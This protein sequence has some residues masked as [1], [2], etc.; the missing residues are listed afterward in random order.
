MSGAVN[1]KAELGT[2]LELE[3]GRGEGLIARPLHPLPP[4]YLCLSLSRSLSRTW[5]L[6][7]VGE[8]VAVSPTRRASSPRSAL[9]GTRRR[10][11]GCTAL[12]AAG[13]RQT[14]WPAA[15]AAPQRGAQPRGVNFGHATVGVAKFGP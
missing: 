4:L 11:I 10:E 6:K 7:M 9:D 3:D 1:A 13:A 2:R 15:G 12:P 8:S 14:G 5:S